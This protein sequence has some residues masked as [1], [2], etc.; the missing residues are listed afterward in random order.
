MENLTL[1]T[2]ILENLNAQFVVFGPTQAW[3]EKLNKHYDFYVTIPN[4]PDKEIYQVRDK[5]FKQIKSSVMFD[6]FRV[7]QRKPHSA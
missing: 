2:R 7:C 1:I 3:V 5:A 4:K 6:T